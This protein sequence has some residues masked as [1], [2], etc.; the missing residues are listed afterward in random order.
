[1]PASP[2]TVVSHP[3]FGC[4]LVVDAGNFGSSD[5]GYEEIL[6]AL[7]PINDDNSVPWTMFN[8]NVSLGFF[9]IYDQL[10]LNILYHPRLRPG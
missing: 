4:L 10:L 8:D 2:T 7:G 9:G 6:Q 1:M 3:P 5:C